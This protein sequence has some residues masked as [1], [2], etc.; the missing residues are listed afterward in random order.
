MGRC[1][2][3]EKGRRFLPV[4]DICST[5]C[6]VARVA[7]PALHLVSGTEA[8]QYI[9]SQP[10]DGGRERERERERRIG[11]A[12]GNGFQSVG[13]GAR[14]RVRQTCHKKSKLQQQIQWKGFRR[15]EMTGGRAR[16][17]LGPVLK[18]TG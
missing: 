14:R 9:I 5:D 17:S 13:R 7:S 2:P 11:E 3:L 4:F 15:F 6:V 1:L 8:K 18:H 12:E 10:S 16:C